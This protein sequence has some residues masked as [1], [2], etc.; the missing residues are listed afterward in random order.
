M[1][2]H[3]IL[4]PEG[5]LVLKPGAPLRKEDFAGLGTAVDAYL[6]DHTR[7]HGVLIHAGAFPGWENFAGFAAHIRFV[8]NH[9]QRIERIAL[10]TD[11]PLATVAE[12]L[13]K[14]FLAAEIRHFAFADYDAALTWLKAP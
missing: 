9:E 10:V 8:R 1:V 3:S 7:L 13:G 14:H 4:K 11:S 2:E 6:A 12:T 5:I